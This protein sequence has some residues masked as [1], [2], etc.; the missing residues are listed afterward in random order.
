MRIESILEG[1]KKLWEAGLLLITDELDMVE[2]M[3]VHLK[4]LV[5]DTEV[6]SGFVNTRE[7]SFA[8]CNK[9]YPWHHICITITT[10][11]TLNSS[12]INFPF[13]LQPVASGSHL[14]ALSL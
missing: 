3:Y 11:K 1:F 9:I 8:H 6:E 7:K 5:D 2:Q 12:A 14:T 4:S 13:H 10:I